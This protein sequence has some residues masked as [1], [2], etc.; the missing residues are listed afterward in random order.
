M[1]HLAVLLTFA[2]LPLA[3]E[4]PVLKATRAKADFDITADPASPHWKSVPAHKAAVDPFGKPA[5]ANAFDFKVQ[6]TPQFVYFH[7]ACP[8][9]D[10]NLKP[11]PATKEETNKLWD[12]DVTEIFIGSDFANIHQYK[13]YQ[14]SPQSEW[15]DLDIDRKN[16]KPQAWAWN[17]GFT[18]AASIDKAKNIWYGAMKIPVSSFAAAPAKAGAEYRMNVYRLAGKAPARQSVMWTPTEN[19]SH[20][21]PEKFGKLVLGQ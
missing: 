14:V 21:T 16:P 11:S 7:F 13:E 20:H 9:S 19:R 17:S 4:E 1:R 6:W 8:Y 3:A 10:L 15:V 18:V 2:A 5:G 12:W